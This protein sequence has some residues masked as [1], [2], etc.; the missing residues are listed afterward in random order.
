MKNRF[1][2]FAMGVSAI[3]FVALSMQSCI[4]ERQVVL[5]GTLYADST[6]TAPVPND[7]ITFHWADG[8][9]FGSCTT[10]GEGKFGFSFWTD[11]ADNWD[12]TYQSKFQIEYN[13]FWVVCKSDTLAILEAYPS[14]YYQHLELYLGKSF[15][16][17]NWR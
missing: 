9:R 13:Q 10:D 8:S 5:R 17:Y 7:T 16:E 15:N 14:T 6:L 11:G 3:L 1:F 4:D 2:G 12:N